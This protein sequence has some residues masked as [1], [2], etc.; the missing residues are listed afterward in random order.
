MKKSRIISLVLAL[1]LLA[2]AVCFAGCQSGSANSA[3]SSGAATT[4]VVG[5][6]ISLTSNDAKVSAFA[7]EAAPPFADV[8][9]LSGWKFQQVKDPV[10]NMEMDIYD[11][12]AKAD[13]LPLHS[14]PD[15]WLCYVTKG[16]GTLVMGDINNN[17]HN[18]VEYKAG[19]YLCFA[20]NLVHAWE[21]SDED[22][23]VI[24][25]CMPGAA[26]SAK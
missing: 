22:T 16:S 13:K 23:Q 5:D 6:I 18:R 25:V 24:F 20:P 9:G 17:E 1:M 3:K 2:A 11:I 26:A 15:A 14:S 12:A 10:T 4:E 21:S 19:D 8:T 7:K